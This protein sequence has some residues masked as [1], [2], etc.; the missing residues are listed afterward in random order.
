VEA[1]TRADE[2]GGGV[3]EAGVIGVLRRRRVA[4]EGVERR[5][6]AEAAL[7]GGLLGGRES[8]VAAEEQ[9]MAGAGGGREEMG[10]EE[11]REGGRWW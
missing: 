2:G 10:V 4:A 6:D 5:L 8:E 7:G 9:E 1:E 11:P 3:G